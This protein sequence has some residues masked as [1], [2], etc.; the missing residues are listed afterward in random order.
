M[1]SLAIF[2]ALISPS[3]YHIL[4]TFSP[5]WP[6]T[7]TVRTRNPLS[8]STGFLSNFTAFHALTWKAQ[9]GTSSAAVVPG[10]CS[11][12]NSCLTTLVLSS[13]HIDSRSSPYVDYRN[14]VPYVGDDGGSLYI[15]TPMFNGN[16]T[17]PL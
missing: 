12:G 2:S 7:P 14:D 8:C 16:R 9:E 6:L 13:T 15:I 5:Y 1:Y 10:N 4:A 11:A 17:L 3:S